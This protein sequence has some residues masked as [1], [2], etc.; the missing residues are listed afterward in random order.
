MRKLLVV[1]IIMCSALS[2]SQCSENALNKYVSWGI[3]LSNNS[4]F[5]SGSFS[6]LEG[7]IIYNDV[8]L[9]LVF[10]RGNLQSVFRNDDIKNYFYELKLSPS[11]PIGKV[12]G[13]IILGAGSYVDT[14]H[15]FIE[16]GLGISY[17]HK[18]ISYGVS[19]SNWDGVDYITPS[20]A[21]NF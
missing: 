21:Y 5:N 18:K 17:T 4:N 14:K 20:I 3:S 9:G 12:Y 13:N 2:W 19:Y 11:F 15:N 10:G 7:G 6:S 8:A 16:Y 1:L